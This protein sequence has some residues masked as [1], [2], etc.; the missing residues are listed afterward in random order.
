M[1]TKACMTLR[2]DPA[3]D[4]LVAEAAH[5]KGVTKTDWIRSAIRQRLKAQQ[6]SRTRAASQG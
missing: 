5:D 4:E 6:D 1:S 3:I 2:L